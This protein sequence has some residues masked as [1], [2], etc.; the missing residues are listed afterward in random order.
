MHLGC[1]KLSDDFWNTQVKNW[2]KTNVS[3]INVYYKRTPVP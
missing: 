3:H 1:L 2:K